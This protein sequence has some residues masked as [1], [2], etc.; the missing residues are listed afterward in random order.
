MEKSQPNNL[1]IGNQGEHIIS[2]EL[3]RY[4]VV[5]DVGQG[6]DTGIDFYCEIVNEKTMELSLHFFCQVKTSKNFNMSSIKDQE[7]TYWG[8]QPVPVFLFEVKYND[9]HKMHD[10]R[11]IWVHDIPYILS[12]R[13]AESLGKNIPP[14]HVDEKFLICGESNNKDKMKLEDFIY[15]HIPWSYGLWHMRRYG[16]VYPNPEIIQKKYDVLVGGFTYLY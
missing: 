8:N 4:C 15:H 14:R 7:F 11:E 16:L 12:R 3:S 10:E 9:R 1:H 13:D 6:K 2:S 5:R